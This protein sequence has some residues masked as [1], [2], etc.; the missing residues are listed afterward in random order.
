MI[1]QFSL[2]SKISLCEFYAS[3]P[4][5]LVEWRDAWL[6]NKRQVLI[7]ELELSDKSTTKMDPAKVYFSAITRAK[8]KPF[9]H[10]LTMGTGASERLENF[11][12]W[13]LAPA[14]LKRM[15]TRV[16]IL[17]DPSFCQLNLQLNAQQ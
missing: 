11:P 14:S 9:K 13:T 4:S 17:T 16:G 12:V 1:S 5:Q 2:D 6:T 10:G 15:Q 3:V 7:L 8:G